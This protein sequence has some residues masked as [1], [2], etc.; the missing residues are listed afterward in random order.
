MLHTMK[1]IFQFSSRLG[2][3]ATDYIFIWLLHFDYSSLFQIFQCKILY[4]HDNKKVYEKYKW[5]YLVLDILY[6]HIRNKHIIER[7]TSIK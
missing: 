1:R 5:L 4:M 3:T 6:S 2:I 7:N